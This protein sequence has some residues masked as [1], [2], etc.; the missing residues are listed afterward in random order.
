MTPAEPTRRRVPGSGVGFTGPS[1]A[2]QLSNNGKNVDVALRA[3]VEVSIA[4]AW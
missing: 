1:V 3:P 4:N 2:L